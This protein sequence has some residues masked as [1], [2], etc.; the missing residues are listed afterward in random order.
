MTDY[1]TLEERW[2]PL[3]RKIAMWRIPGMDYD[4]VMQEMRIVLFNA[5]KNY[6]PGKHAKFITFL[7]VSCLNTAL[8]LLYKAGEGAKPRKST[9][10]QSV[11]DP[12]CDGD[13]GDSISCSWCAAQGSAFA[14]DDLSV[15]DLLSHATPEAKTIAGLILRGDTSKRA[16]FDHGLSRRQIRN[17]SMELQSLLKG[18]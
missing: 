14:M 6:D 2:R 9:V 3:L 8:K 11:V 5:Q 7:Y 15:M 12:L 4:D 18:G 1:E 10:P 17:G 16:W 13:H